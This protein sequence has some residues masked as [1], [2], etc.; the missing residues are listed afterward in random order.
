[1][2][3]ENFAGD[4]QRVVTLPE[5]GNYISLAVMPS[6]VIRDLARREEAI[7]PFRLNQ[8]HNHDALSPTKWD[9]SVPFICS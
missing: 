5:G 7:S 6:F 3:I 4:E 1:M 2:K 8:R 9:C